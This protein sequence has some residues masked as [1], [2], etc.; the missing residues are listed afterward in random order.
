MGRRV[1]PA[2]EHAHPDGLLS[3]LGCQVDEAGF[4]IVDASGRT[5]T[6]GV[7]AAGNVVDARLQV[8]SSAGAGSAAAIAINAD[9]VQ[10][11]VQRAVL[12]PVDPVASHS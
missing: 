8:I 3:G 10:E 9:L 5:S 7:W 1:H 11:D 2:G 12:G 6:V 4:A